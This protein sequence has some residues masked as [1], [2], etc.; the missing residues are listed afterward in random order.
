MPDTKQNG[1]SEDE[2]FRSDTEKTPT[3]KKET[4]FEYHR[5]RVDAR[6]CVKRHFAAQRARGPLKLSTFT[7]LAA[8]GYPSTVPIIP[9]DAPISPQSSL[10]KRV[11]TRQ[12]ARGKTPGV[13]GR[14]GLWRSFDWPRYTPDARDYARWTDMGAGI[15]IRTGEGL[16]A[17]DAD[18]MDT[19]CAAI[20]RDYVDTAFAVR[21]PVRVGRAPKALYVFRTDG[22]VPYQR[23]DFGQRDERGTPERVELLTE[24]RQFVAV[25]V[26][27]KTGKPY[28]WERP[29]V[30]FD[31]L[32]FLPADK[33]TAF[34]EGLRKLLP[35]AEPL[36]KEGGTTEVDQASL[37]GDPATVRKA[38]QATPNTSA[39]FATRES[40][41]GL[42]YAIKA[43]VEDEAEAFGIWEEWCGRWAEGD[44]E[45]DVM[46]A[47]WRRMKPPY[48]RGAQWIYDLADRV[49]DGRFTVA[50]AWF[51]DVAETQ[52]DNPFAVAATVA[53]KQNDTGLYPLLTIGEIISRPPPSFLVARHIPDISVGFLYSRPGAG[54]SFLAI[55]LGL[56]VAHGLPDWHGDPIAAIE[57][58]VVIYIAAEG[59]F[60][61]GNRIRAWHAAKGLGFTTRFLVIERTIEFMK[62]DDVDRLLRTVR[63]AHLK[64]A[65][66]VVD[67]VSRAMPG[68][69]ENLQKDMTLFVKAC[70]RVRDEFACAVLGVHHAGKNGDMRGSTV[71][72]GAGDFVFRLERKERAPIGTLACEKQ[73]A[74]EDGWE[75]PYRF[76]RVALDDGQSSLVPVRGDMVMG[77]EGVLTPDST[78]RVLEAMQAAWEAGAPWSKTARGGERWAVRRMVADF[79]FK[80]DAAEEMLRMWLAMGIVSVETRGAKSKLVGYKVGGIPGQA[81]LNGGIFD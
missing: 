42:G 78:R 13:K 22:P 45:P 48:R 30:P 41:L 56:H 9:P 76:D 60:D 8:A 16:L 19:R 59:S 38:V 57:G 75:E 39:V 77:P 23:I 40:Y 51:E 53:E 17:L 74:A 61:L 12:D 35:A 5:Q 20:V 49:S 11:G 6:P 32:P 25:G 67:T 63:A 29:L 66:V 69:D 7:K 47:D 1:P 18:T 65:L 64:P 2:P 71:L 54:K 72:R 27:P 46:A 37:R 50:E 26:H 15:G 68:A 58:S 62:A 3:E 70:D 81:V 4:S 55:D 33:V 34:M 43:A 14:D 73:K 24:G 79:N 21:S 52:A 80:G 28:T 36:V 44:N 31:D 10:Y